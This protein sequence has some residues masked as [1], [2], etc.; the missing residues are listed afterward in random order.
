MIP[1]YIKYNL[2]RDDKKFSNLPRFLFNVPE[3]D[4]EFHYKDLMRSNYY[5]A[6]VILRHYIKLTSDY[7]FGIKLGAKNIDLFMLTPSISSPMG[8]GSDSKSVKIKFG[9]FNTFLTDSAQFGF[10]PLLLNGFDKVY[11][12]MPSIRGDNPDSRHL[13]QFFH[14]EAEIRGELENLIPIIEGYIKILAETVLLMEN[15]I[16]KISDDPVKT[17]QFLKGI[18][19][20][21]KFSKITFKKAIEILIK[22]NKKLIKF[23][24]YGRNINSNGEIELMKIL[25]NKNPIWLMQFDRNIVPFYQKPNPKNKER[26]INADLLFPPIITNSFGGEIVGSGQRQNS[27][28]EIN[29]SLKRQSISPMSYE[30]YINIRKQPGYKT[31][32]GFG[33]GIERFIAWCLGKENIRDVAL[34]P[35]IINVKTHP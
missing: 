32:S 26:T 25:K 12:Y 23:N 30:W 13:N 11:C 16:D 34:Y 14:C 5:N 31:T 33:L 20:A 35:R 8:P 22:K 19:R 9:K 29:E 17:R 4:P 6:L 28:K 10:E 2:L 3:Y 21:K 15:I 24:R 27:A 7:Y 18:I 1:S